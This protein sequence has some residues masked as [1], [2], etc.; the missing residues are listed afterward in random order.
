MFPDSTSI[1]NRVAQKCVDLG[2]PPQATTA[3]LAEL[4]DEFS[5]EWQDLF[6]EASNRWANNSAVLAA[7]RQVR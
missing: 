1:F 4:V 5:D 3:I 6:D 7:F 2:I